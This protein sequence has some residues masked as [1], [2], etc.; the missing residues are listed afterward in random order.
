MRRTIW[1]AAAAALVI[2]S[3]LV[4]QHRPGSPRPAAA[5]AAG[6]PALDEI[7]GEQI[8]AHVQFLADDLLEGR[9]PSTRGGQLAAQYLA[10]QLALLGFEPGAADGTY[11][12][13]V[14]IVESEVNPSF[15]LTAG[16]GMP[17]TYL[18]DVVAFSDIQEPTVRTS[19]EIVFVGHGI[20]APEYEWN[21]YA[22]VDMRGKLA[23]I[24]VND[25]PATP[26]EPQRFGGPALTYYGRWTYKFEEAA[27][28]GAAGAILVHTDESATYGWQ[29]VQSSWSG[30]QY[31]IPAV[32]GASRLGLKAW[33]T[34]RAAREIVTRAGRELDA[35]REAAVR[36]GAKPVPLGIQASATIVQTVQQKTSPNVIGVLRGTNPNQAVIYTAHYDHLG[37]RDPQPGE[38]A[39]ADRIFN[40]ATDNASGV[41]GVLEIAQAMARAPARP[42]RSVYVLFTTAEESGLLGSEYFAGRPVLPPEAWAANLNVDE[43]NLY[44]PSR[45]IV[46]LGAERST[47]GA[48]ASQ[49][50]ADERRVVGPDPEP[51]RGYF[52]RSDHFPLAKIG[53]PALS[54]SDPV[55]FIGPD[56][57]ASKRLHDE[58]QDKRYHQP[59]DEVLR[60]WDYTGAISDL[61]FL[62]ELGWRIA[63]LAEMPAYHPNEQF[64]RPRVKAT[65]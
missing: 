19:G 33:V 31:S 17:F 62:A 10:A 55:D 36:R 23:L 39:D 43:L 60:S 45:D 27:R 47:L 53:I 7:G 29:V 30:R 13:Q 59:D 44:G 28:Q 21:D 12:Q 8:A 65:H 3:V 52:F 6:Q 35:L 49:L 51:G 20:V 42:A 58:Y 14:P 22:G 50:A 57:A 41:A 48:L 64:A 34:D 2:V 37:V 9:A 5:G 32:P 38:P 15:T 24:M 63:N 11:F 25:P 40:G 54:L 16:P 1:L 18:R 26:E 46:L 61:R 56:V 4:A